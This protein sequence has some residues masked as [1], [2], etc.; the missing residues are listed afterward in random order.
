MELRKCC[1]HPFLVKGAEN[2]LTKHLDGSSPLDI[3]VKTSGKM[4]C[5][6]I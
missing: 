6:K 3:M 4:V 2:E 1:N 5:Y